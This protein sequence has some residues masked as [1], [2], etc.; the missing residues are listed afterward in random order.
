[1]QLTVKIKD[2]D[3]AQLLYSVLKS[4]DFV[5]HVSSDEDQEIAQRT[6]SGEHDRSEEFFSYA[7]LWSE[8]DISVINLRHKAWPRQNK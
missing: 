3:K 5:L 6:L 1:M 2:P 4:L 7:G 8:R